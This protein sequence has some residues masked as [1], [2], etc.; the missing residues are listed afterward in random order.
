MR[1]CAYESRNDGFAGTV[2][3]L[4]IGAFRGRGRYDRFDEAVA[5]YNIDVRSRRIAGAIDQRRIAENG[6]LLRV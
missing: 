3:P 1:V 4:F 5:E 2:H 6:G